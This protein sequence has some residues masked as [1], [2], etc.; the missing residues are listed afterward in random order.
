MR[1]SLKIAV[2]A[3]VLIPLAGGSAATAAPCF[4]SSYSIAELPGLGG[5]VTQAV[6]IAE[7]GDVG[8]F[9][10]DS[11]WVSHAVRWRGGQVTS[12]S[13]A[14]SAGNGISSSGIVA[15]WQSGRRGL[16][17]TTWSPPISLR[18]P[19][20]SV[21][22]QAS[23]VNAT[24]LAVGW[25]SNS[26]GDTSAVRWDG[27][28]PTSLASGANAPSISLA[29]AVNDAGTIVG[30]GDFATEPFRRALRWQDTT[31]TTLPGLGSG[32]DS[33]TAISQSGLVTGGGLSPADSKFHAV[34]WNGNTVTDLG[35]FGPSPTSGWGV[36]TCG[37]VVGDAVV[38]VVDD[39]TEA[40]IWRGG[41]SAMALESLL[42]AGHGWDLHVARAINDTG[43]VVG[44]GYRSGMPGLRSFLMT[45]TG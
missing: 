20:G 21:G 31:M 8:G 11:S 12:L 5:P 32:Y 45:P 6:A 34:L 1:L 9:S 16:Q 39:I 23:D 3:L 10:L 36:N 2:A 41:E 27:P 17:A 40:V 22:A 7:N 43:Q 35:L 26:I 18:L 38:S 13:T 14:T 37:T 4:H 42:P 28:R 30:R 44:Y 33:A 29:A 19:R 24:G 15:G 25:S